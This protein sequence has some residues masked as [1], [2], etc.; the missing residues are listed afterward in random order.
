ME[1]HPN[2]VVERSDI[3]FGDFVQLL[4]QGAAAGQL[5]DVMLIDNP[6]FHA[7]ASLR[8]R[9]NSPRATLMRTDTAR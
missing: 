6:D 5:P 2:I 9:I 4:V 3:P 1:S 7:F 8:L